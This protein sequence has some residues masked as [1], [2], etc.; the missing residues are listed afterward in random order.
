MEEAVECY[1]ASL[2]IRRE[3]KQPHLTVEIEALLAHL[4]LKQNDLAQAVA[5]IDRVMAYLQLSNEQK[6]NRPFLPPPSNSQTIPIIRQLK[7]VQ[8]PFRVY[9][10]CYHVLQAKGDD[11]GTAVLDF[12]ADLL[13]E[14]ANLLDDAEL[15]KSFL[16][17]VPV[18]R[19]ILAY[20]LQVGLES[21]S[22]E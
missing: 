15:E 17:N 11:R 5:S 19:Q 3:L 7:G 16:E 6:G 12:A 20:N 2:T 10:D 13:Q 4:Y 22:L 18:N 21:K 14:Q 1:M 9:L 8:D